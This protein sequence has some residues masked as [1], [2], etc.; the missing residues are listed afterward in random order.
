MA[1][2]RRI[3]GL[4]GG[5]ATGKSTVTNYLQEH[6]RLVVL[7]ADVLAREAVQPRSPI[8]DQIFQHFGAGI[9]TSA[10]TLDR[11]KLAEIIFNQPAERQ[12]LEAQIHPYVRQRFEVALAQNRDRLLVFSIPLLFEAQMTDLV[13]EIWVVSC[14]LAMQIKRLQQRNQLSREQAIARIESQMPLADK[15]ALADRV[16]VNAG[17]LDELYQQVDS[18]IAV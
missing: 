3:I 8:S 4:T 18:A 11:A 13:T 17:A 6:Y 14:P 5:I 1:E 7:D 2:T 9:Q 15:I 16:I 10:G 12:L